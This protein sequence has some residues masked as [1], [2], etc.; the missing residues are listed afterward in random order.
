MYTTTVSL[1]GVFI[2]PMLSNN[3]YKMVKG[4]E[5]SWVNE[6]IGMRLVK[7]S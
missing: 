1:G 7:E 3:F 2:K 6:K 4:N 5:K